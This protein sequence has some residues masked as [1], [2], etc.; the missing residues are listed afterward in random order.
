MK[1]GLFAFMKILFVIGGIM[2]RAGAETIVMNY[3]RK[4][5]SPTLQFDFAVHGFEEGAYDKEIQGLGAKIHHSPPR[6]HVLSNVRA[7]K[8]IMHE[9]NYDIVHSHADVACCFS[10]IAAKQSH[11][12][13]RIAHSHNTE[14][15]TKNKIKLFFNQ[16]F[17]KLTNVYANEYFACSKAAGKFMFGNKEFHILPNAVDLDTFKYSEED[18]YYYRKKLD[19]RDEEIAVL[20]IARFNYQKNH[21]FIIDVFKSM[22]EINNKCKLYL[23]GDGEE[24]LKTQEYVK[25]LNIQNSVFFTG[26]QE[27]VKIYYLACDVFIMPSLFEG[28]PVTGVEAQAMG[29]PCVFS[30]TITREVELHPHTKYLPLSLSHFKWAEAVLD[31]AKRNKSR[32]NKNILVEKGFD[33]DTESTKLKHFYISKKEAI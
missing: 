1:E 10:M 11:V 19:I 22:L 21:K 15:Q 9:N 30:D 12:S 17:R 26:V 33:L 16:M 24:K 28:L 18:R 3:F 13:V 29:L 25:K 27:N 14:F 7:L 23:V 6:N 2:N 32:D 5:Q 20:S 4:L 8:K 31:S